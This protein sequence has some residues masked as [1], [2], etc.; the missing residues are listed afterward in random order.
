M[1]TTS[2]KSSDGN[3]LEKV[4]VIGSGNW[5]SAIAMIAAINAEANPKQFE[6]TITMW[7]KEE[8]FKGHPLTEVINEKHEN[9]RYL[10]GINLGQNVHAEPDLE[11]AIT[12][13]TAFVIVLPHQFVE[14]VMKQMAGKIRPDARAVTLIKGI[15]FQDNQ[16]FPFA[17]V[18]QKELN[19][20]CSALCGAN[21]AN[22]VAAGSFSES[23]LGIP[24]SGK[25]RAD[26]YAKLLERPEVRL[27]KTLFETPKFRIRVVEDVEG[28]CLC[29]ALKNVVA[30]AAGF[31][32]GL[33]WGD[34]AKSAIMRIGLME[35]HDFGREFFPSTKSATFLQESCG[36]ADIMTSCMGGRNRKVAMEMV[37]SAKGSISLLRL[38]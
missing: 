1:A 36:V 5:G 25:E 23:T 11:K 13:A 10:P 4:T 6:P 20:P 14:N 17:S 33:E 16:I 8:D 32:D 22:E 15:H 2:N 3:R 31:I 37:K 21:I 18:I 12:D 27:W 26:S 29:G 28:V 9:P 7:V 35:I 38:G 34:N 30:L 24:A 19:I